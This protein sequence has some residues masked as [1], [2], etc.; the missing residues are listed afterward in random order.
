MNEPRLIRKQQ[1]AYWLWFSCSLLIP[2]YFG[3]IS[4]VFAF[5]HDYIIQDD[6][7]QHIVWLQ[8]Y[9]DPSLFP[10]DVIADYFLSV[11]PLGYKGF[12]WLLAKLG[13]EPI[14]IAKILPLLLATI[15]TYY[16]FL[17]SYSILPLP[18]SSCWSCLFFN[19]LIWL[20]DDLV[21]ATPRAFVYPLFTA[22]IYYF[23]KRSLLP[24]LIVMTLQGLFYPQI[25]LVQL[26]TIFISTLTFK[27]A[28][29]S[30]H[31]TRK[32]AI[33]IISSSIISIL[34]LLPYILIKSPFEP[35]VNSQQ[36]WLMPEFN[37]GGRSQY[38]GVNFWLFWFNGSS[39]LRIPSFPAIVWLGFALAIMTA[40]DADG[41]SA[42]PIAVLTNY[43]TAITKLINPKIKIIYQIL[44]ASLLMFLLAHLLL[45]KLHLPSRYTYHSWRILMAVATGIIIS[46]LINQIFMTQEKK[47]FGAI[48]PKLLKQLTVT[49]LIIIIIFPAIPPVFINWFQNWHIGNA[50]EIYQYL[51]SQPKQI[52]V[53]SL[54]SEADNLPAFTHRSVL[55]AREFALPY[56]TKYYQQFQQ[57]TIDL[58]QSQYSSDLTD[59]QKTIAK[60]NLDYWLLDHNA[61]TNNYL[62]QQDWLINSSFQAITQ[63]A[64]AKIQ[65]QEEFAIA[66]LITQAQCLVVSTD[67]LFLLDTKC[68]H[69]QK[70]N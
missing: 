22:F 2:F 57:K 63:N 48:K 35:V 55:V 28:K 23:S 51:A 11:A 15:A 3:L 44:A 50:R 30:I 37:W 19:Q 5:H 16:L 41:Q 8:K 45:P 56:H 34:V 20:N 54:A 70:P 26:T 58:I 21:S 46:V 66:K 31:L 17:I 12:Y 68:I 6:A 52:I 29:P 62:K 47:L 36:M 14:I 39:G 27:K 69:R 64:I 40:R 24:C 10:N 33:F 18:L 42:Y 25:L 4:L 60:Y 67:N 59:I 13:I 61:F 53:A 49:V 9:F 32:Q 38:F 7:R 43:Q 65:Q 1:Q